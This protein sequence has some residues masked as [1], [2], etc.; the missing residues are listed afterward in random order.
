[1][2]DNNKFKNKINTLEYNNNLSISNLESN[3]NELNYK[4]LNI[5]LNENLV[6][7]IISI[8]YIS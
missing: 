3:L 1:M 5:I 8:S 4:S 7:Y 2:D 6:K